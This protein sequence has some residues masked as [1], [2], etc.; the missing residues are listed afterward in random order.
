MPIWATLAAYGREGHRAM[1]E[2]HVGIAAHLARLV[3]EAPDFE[4]LAPA[5]LCI[6]CFRYAPPG[7]PE[8]ELDALNTA[9]GQR[10]IADGR[11]YAGTTRYRGRAAFR[12]A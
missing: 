12:P 10:L 6:V 5:P 1:V 7:V 11:V 4:L 3:T 9:L 8:E 2:R